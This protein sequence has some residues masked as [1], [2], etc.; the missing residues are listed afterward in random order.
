MAYILPLKTGNFRADVRMKGIIK[1]KTFPSIL[2]AEGWA[3]TV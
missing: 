2:L 1:N 3:N